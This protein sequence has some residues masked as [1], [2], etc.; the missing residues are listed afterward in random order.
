MR[1]L[2]GSSPKDIGL[3][4]SPRCVGA[5]QAQTCTLGTPA[6]CEGDVRVTC[7]GNLRRQ[8][9]KDF[10][11]RTCVSGSCAFGAECDG[12]NTPNKCIGTT[13]EMCV[14]G[15]RRSVECS[16]IGA[17]SCLSDRCR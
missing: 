8:D 16:A 14:G 7:D 12:P 10:G 6:T 17:T 4:A 2:R 5:L 11:G 3:P 1:G 9:C 15:V 13:L